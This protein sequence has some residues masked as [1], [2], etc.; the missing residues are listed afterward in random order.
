MALALNGARK[1]CCMKMYLQVNEAG[2]QAGAGTGERAGP[3]EYR[4]CWMGLAMTMELELELA[5]GAGAGA[6]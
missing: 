5:C 1:M 2:D 6:A 3:G 4:C